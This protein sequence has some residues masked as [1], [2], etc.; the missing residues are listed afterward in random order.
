ME[1]IQAPFFN[2]DNIMRESACDPAPSTTQAPTCN[3]DQR[4]FKAYL[5][6]FMAYTYQ[7]AP[8][9]QEWI[10]PRLQASAKAGAATCTGGADG[11]T[12]G[13][14]W[15]Q[16]T[17]DGSVFGVT[18]GGLG[19]HLAV[20]EVLQSNLIVTAGAPLTA[21]TGGTSKGDPTA[22]TTE[23]LTTQELLQTEPST[24]GDKA[25]AGIL[26]TIVLGLLFSLTYWLV[27]F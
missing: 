23:K 20:M 4:S 1:A 16:S 8:F 10:I 9:T 11:I 5:A 21:T 13:L 7:M 26:T 15:V 2:A 12:C 17:Y 3:L 27:R 19:E 22:G 24:V 14:A 25:G 6:R 18:A